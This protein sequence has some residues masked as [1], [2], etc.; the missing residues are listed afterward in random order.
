MPTGTGLKTP[1][2]ITD[3]NS[4]QGQDRSWATIN[5]AKTDN[6]KAAYF[7]TQP[8]ESNNHSYW[9]Q[10]T[11]FG[12]V[13]PAS[14]V[15]TGIKVRMKRRVYD[16]TSDA[17]ATLDAVELIVGGSIQSSGSTLLSDSAVWKRS[18]TFLDFDDITN[19]SEINYPD[20]AS[21]NL[22]DT[23]VE[24]SNF[25]VAIRVHTSNIGSGYVP[26][27][28]SFVQMEV[29]YDDPPPSATSQKIDVTWNI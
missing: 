29:F 1:G 21:L 15:I 7:T 18:R 24:A 17:T 25:G 4:N 28:I 23:D 26:V 9:L 3:V 13:V 16:V 22:L 2:T 20:K 11:N 8:N 14:K 5:D 27:M 10:C 19:G 6:N 12:F